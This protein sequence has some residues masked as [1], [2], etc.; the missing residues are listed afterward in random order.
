RTELAVAVDVDDGAAGEPLGE[1]SELLEVLVVAGP[2]DDEAAIRVQGERGQGL[3]LG[4]IGIDP[5]LGGLGRAG[6]VE[7]PGEDAVVVAVLAGAVPGDDEAADGTH[8]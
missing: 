4:R 5:E 7:A 1:D 2:G 6:A 3:S 8:V